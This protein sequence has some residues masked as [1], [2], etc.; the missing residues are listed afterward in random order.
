MIDIIITIYF[1]GAM[2]R[3]AS[4]ASGLLRPATDIYLYMYIYTYTYVL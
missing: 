2:L 3:S 4:Q 1:P